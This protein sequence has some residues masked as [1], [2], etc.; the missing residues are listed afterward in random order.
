MLPL[1]L[2]LVRLKVVLV[3]NGAAAERRLALLDEAGA[4]DLVVYA[5][6]PSWPLT[7][8]AGSRLVRRMPSTSELAS[9]RLVFVAERGLPQCRELATAARAGGA[10]VHV[11]DEPAL[12]DVHAPATLR[13][14]A[15][16]IAV[17]TGGKSPALAAQLKR[18]LGTLFGPE[19][20]GRVDDLAVLRRRWRAKGADTQTV[21]R[22]TEEWVARQGW[23]A[24]E[25]GGHPPTGRTAPFDTDSA[26]RH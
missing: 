14:G 24:A 11:E 26:T 2:D 18:F 1:A 7:R 3:G 23:L 22:R 25:D 8:A 21:A 15:L 6:A 13:R 5:D 19:W 16:T 4:G 20:R 17:A 9:A 12:S 10:L